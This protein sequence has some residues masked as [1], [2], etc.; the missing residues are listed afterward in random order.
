MTDKATLAGITVHL[1]D[2]HGTSSTCPTCRWRISKPRGRTL[3]CPHCQFSSHR[4]VIAAASIA[5][6]TRAADPPPHTR[7]AAR[8]DHA[9]S[10]RP[11][12]TR[13][14]PALT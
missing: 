9:P 13:H 4:D 1:V 8:G 6:R 11:A 2:E 10:S 7:R 12:P 14:R 5:T 3:T